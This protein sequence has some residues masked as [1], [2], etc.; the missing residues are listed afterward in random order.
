VILVRSGCSGARKGNPPHCLWSPVEKLDAPN[1]VEARRFVQ[2]ELA[3]RLKDERFREEVSFVGG[4]DETQHQELTVLR[5]FE[6]IGFYQ[7]KGFVEQDVLLMAASG[8]IV[9]MWI[10]LQP[11]VEIHRKALGNR[12]WENFEALHQQTMAQMRERGFDTDTALERS[13]AARA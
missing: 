2:F 4:V 6:R 13:V 12:V 9:T 5:C 7:A 1:Q 11:I 10:A 3:D 8:R